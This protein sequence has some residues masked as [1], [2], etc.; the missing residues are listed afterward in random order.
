[1]RTMLAPRPAGT[2]GGPQ[3]KQT[4]DAG[5]DVA[6]DAMGLVFRC[7]R[8]TSGA[9]LLLQ[10]TTCAQDDR[11]LIPVTF[12]VPGQTLSTS[13]VYVAQDMGTFEREGL[14]VAIRTVAGVAS[15]NAVLAGSADFTIGAGPAFLRAAAQG[16]RFVAIANV[17]DR[18]LV[19]LVVGRTAAGRLGIRPDMPETERSRRLKGAVIAISGVGSIVHAWERYVVVRAG[20][21]PDR[22]VRI[23]PMDPSAMLAA[24]SGGSIDG[25]ATSPPVTTEALVSGAAVAVAS[26]V[27]ETDLLP[28]PYGLIYTTPDTCVRHRDTCARLARAFAAAAGLVRDAPA[29]VYDRVI[30]PRFNRVATPVL[31]AAW[32][33]VR[34]AHA[35]DVR[36]T[37]ALLDNA[38]RLSETALFMSPKAVGDSDKLYTNE[39]LP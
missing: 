17:V 6:P 14:D 37:P 39:F 3:R 16:Q 19:E 34:Q 7:L 21:D 25:F 5:S 35:G 29:R 15:A 4:G 24:M 18:P 1:M 26:A 2:D 22:D 10:L 27:G 33:T 9:L 38:R 11:G 12:A 8:R 36:V 31:T 30:Q 32:E 20:L 13:I 23:V 28:F